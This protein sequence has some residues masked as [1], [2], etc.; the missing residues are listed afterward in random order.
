MPQIPWQVTVQD[1]P[2]SS[3]TEIEKEPDW[4]A[5][6]SQHR[7][8]FKNR[9]DRR[10]G[11]THTNDDPSEEAPGLSHSSGSEEDLDDIAAGATARAGLAGL[12]ARKSQGDLLSFSDLISHQPD[13]HLKHPE[14]KSLGWRYLLNATEDWVKYGQ[15][16]PANI[17]R[18]QK[19]QQA[20]AEKESKTEDG[21][22]IVRRDTQKGSDESQEENDWRRKGD[23]AQKHHDAYAVDSD[24]PEKPQSEYQ[25]PLERYTPQEIALLK[26]LQHEKDYRKS[27]KQNDGKLE[28]PQKHNRTT[29]AIDE[30]DQFTPDNWLPRSDHLIRLTGKH[31]L[32]A[33]AELT[34]LFKSGLITPNELHYVRNHGA[35][36]RLL[37]ELHELDVEGGKLVLS[38]D[39]LKHKFD[40]INIPVSLACDGN[41]RKELNMLQKVERVQLGFWSYRLCLLERSA[42]TR[43]LGRCWRRG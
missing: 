26:T 19:Q 36:P 17:Q 35:V 37:W 21:V 11:L 39:D 33:E 16:W 15:E 27:L 3:Q 41:R 14:N 30:Q 29:I 18:K 5:A 43:R 31:P 20:N 28:S 13:L 24:T 7:V 23:G 8:G 22:Q 10:P 32:N 1:H 4:G 9:Q 34:A 2:G 25:K 6:G 42:A 12:E 38:M 40:T